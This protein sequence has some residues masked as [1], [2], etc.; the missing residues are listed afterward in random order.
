MISTNRHG[1]R[2]LLI[3]S[4]SALVDSTSASSILHRSLSRPRP[5]PHQNCLTH[6]TDDFEKKQQNLVI[7]VATCLERAET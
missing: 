2:E 1:L 5:R 6:I 4:A 3:A 7:T